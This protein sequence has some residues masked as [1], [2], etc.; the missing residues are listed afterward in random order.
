MNKREAVKRLHE[1]RY[2]V[3]DS[4]T[5][6]DPTYGGGE[7]DAS[8]VC[9]HLDELLQ[10]LLQERDEKLRCLCLSPRRQR[11]TDQ[12]CLACK[13]VIVDRWADDADDDEGGPW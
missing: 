6:Y 1:L 7:V 4:R 13:G 2:K 10:I 9:A 11:V 3:E 8:E 5:K 12:V